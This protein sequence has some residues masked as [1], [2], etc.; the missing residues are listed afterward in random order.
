MF[1]NSKTVPL[2]LRFIAPIVLPGMRIWIQTQQRNAMSA[3]LVTCQVARI[4]VAL[5]ARRARLIWIATLQQCAVIARLENSL[6][7]E[8]P[9]AQH[10]LQAKQTRTAIRRRHAL[11]VMLV[12]FQLAARRP[13]LRVN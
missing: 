11:C 4:P 8:P 13:A 10:V 5:H 9:I 3:L 2:L 12:S 6:L 1:R 7:R